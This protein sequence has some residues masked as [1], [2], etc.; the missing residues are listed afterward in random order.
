MEISYVEPMAMLIDPE[1]SGIKAG[2]M[3]VVPIPKI[4][5]GDP[6]NYDHDYEDLYEIPEGSVLCAGQ[7]LQ[8]ELYPRLSQVFA[9][10]GGLKDFTLPDLREKFVIGISAQTGEPVL[11]TAII[12]FDD[13]PAPAEREVF[14]RH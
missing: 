5:D 2:M 10:T 12:Y 6:R 13:I 11:G 1:N 4:E 7:T 14:M 9:G 8:R 3:S